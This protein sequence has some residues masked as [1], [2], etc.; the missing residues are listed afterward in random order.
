MSLISTDPVGPLTDPADT[1][2]NTV[3]TNSPFWPSISTGAFRLAKRLG[4]T[5]TT[6]R[7]HHCLKVAMGAVNDQLRYWMT[8]Q[9]TRGF[10][11]LENVPADAIDGESVLITRYREAVYSYAK[12]TLI[13]GYRDAD[14]TG[15]GEAHAIALAT[16]IDDCWRDARWAIRDIKGESRGMAELL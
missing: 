4:G 12:A 9:R 3:I 7:L 16:Q 1:G 8:E 13:E 14:T 15:K 10:S 5:S 6:D 2:Q 11:S